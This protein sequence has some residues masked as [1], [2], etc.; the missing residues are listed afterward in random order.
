MSLLEINHVK[1]QFDGKR[2]L[3]VVGVLADK[4]YEKVVGEVLPYATKTAVITPDN[5]RALESLKLLKVVEK[6]CPDAVDAKT[7]KEGL[8]WALSKAGSEDVVIIFGSLS[9]M[10]EIGEYYGEISKNYTA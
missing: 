6:Y 5:P 4:E 2:V 8:A 9:F 3:A 7:A 10:G 1:K